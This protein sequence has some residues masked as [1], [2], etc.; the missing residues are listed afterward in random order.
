MYWDRAWS[1]VEG[2]TPWS[3]ECL[4][5]W[6]AEQ[7]H[8]R[9]NHPTLQ[10]RARYCGLT[11]ASGQFNGTV[12]F[13]ERDLDKPLRIRKPTVWAVWN[14]LFHANV[15]LEQIGW[16]WDVIER[17][18]QH[19]FLVLTKR[20]ERIGEF[21]RA[22]CTEE[23]PWPLPNVWLGTTIG[24]PDSLWR[25]DELLKVPAAVKFLSCEPLLESL[26]PLWPQW[27]WPML[28]WVII[29]PET[30]RNRRECKPEWIK[31][32]IEQADAA[33][34]PVFIKAFPVG[35]R[36]SKDMAEWP[37]WARRREFPTTAEEGE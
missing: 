30:G 35:G 5:C 17:V 31:S 33:G 11:N 20:P 2:C 3:P 27:W 13:M 26:V 4:H 23:P 29:G 9:Q 1:L 8:R 19:T 18:P 7:T 21:F 25:I 6:S 14:D 15:S 36:V 28:S 37:E 24:H 34:L 32:L 16:V 22:C 10:T 12:R